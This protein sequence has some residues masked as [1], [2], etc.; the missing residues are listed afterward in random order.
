[1]VAR[2]VMHLRGGSRHEMIVRYRQDLMEYWRSSVAPE[3]PL[4][5]RLA[6]SGSSPAGSRI[7]LYE[8]TWEN[9]RPDLEVESL[10]LVSAVGASSPIIFAVTLE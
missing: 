6:W 5:G 1:M 3:T 2:Y 8:G 9:P 7:A 10:D 4:L